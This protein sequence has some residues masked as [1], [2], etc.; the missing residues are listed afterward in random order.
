MPAA[1]PQIKGTAPTPAGQHVLAG[2]GLRPQHYADALAS[3]KAVAFIEV[4][5]ENYLC[6]G[7]PQHHY[8]T[9]LRE[10]LPL[11]LHG[12]GLSL[13]GTARPDQGHLRRLRALADRYQPFR[14]S[15]HLA[16]SSHGGHYFNDLLPLPYTARNLG[17]MVDHVVEVQEALG[18][19]ILIENPSLYLTFDESEM[20]EQEFLAALARRSGCGLLLDINN[21]YVSAVNG[22]A[23][24]RAGLAAF[25][26]PAVAEIHLAGHARQI[27]ADAGVLLIDAHDAPVADAVWQL[28]AEAAAMMPATPVLIEWD[29][30]LPDWG[31]LTAEARQARCLAEQV[32]ARGD[33]AAIA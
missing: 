25:P 10:S 7:G 5:P 28:Y 33:H 20:S 15:E 3:P 1:P 18:R 11:S 17:R 30:D 29:N 14:F 31:T 8:L 26:L 23:D 4:H 2:V 9:R 19:Q 21:L 22:G 24:A 32:L 13:G 6:A 12:V 27:D 16:W